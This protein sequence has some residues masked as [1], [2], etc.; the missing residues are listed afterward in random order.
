MLTLKKED[1]QKIIREVDTNDLVLALKGASK[2]LM[3]LILKSMSK[4]AADSLK[5]E[6][7]NLGPVK[8]KIVEGAR[9]K[10]VTLVRQM[11]TSG[12]LIL[13]DGE[14]EPMLP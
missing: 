9:D 13:E 14:D 5:E 7:E 2:E 6:L 10:I 8:V 3:E 11:E 12:Q 4:R 1:V